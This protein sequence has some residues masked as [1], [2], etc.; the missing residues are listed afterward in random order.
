MISIEGDFLLE[1]LNIC[2]FFKGRLFGEGFLPSMLL[3]K[4]M[5]IISMTPSNHAFANLN[6]DA[7]A[8]R[9]YNFI[10][11]EYTVLWANDISKGGVDIL[12]L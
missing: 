5:Q 12:Y 8:R 4:K 7:N 6:I 11:E 3:M 10:P 2:I 9:R 1:E